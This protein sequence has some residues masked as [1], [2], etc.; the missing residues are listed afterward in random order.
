[1]AKI[2][3]VL[4]TS[5]DKYTSQHPVGIR[6]LGS[7]GDWGLTWN[8]GPWPMPPGSSILILGILSS[9]PYRPPTPCGSCACAHRY[10][11]LEVQQLNSLLA[12]KHP[13]YG[14]VHPWKDGDRE[15][16]Y[17]MTMWGRELHP[18][19]GP[20]IGDMPSRRHVLFGPQCRKRCNWTWSLGETS[21]WP[22]PQTSSYKIFLFSYLIFRAAPAAYRGSQARGWIGA[23][24]ASL[25]HSHSNTRSEPQLRPISQLTATP[26]P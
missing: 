1:M 21:V 4:S 22:H 19:G 13:H 11:R 2:K 15:E 17:S 24:A 6:I 26:D 5:L 12:L 14:T 9:H 10:S 23:L 20:E 8:T 7:L 18:E 16:T 25:C 3:Y